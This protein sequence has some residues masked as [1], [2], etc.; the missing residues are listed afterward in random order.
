MKVTEL[1][2]KVKWVQGKRSKLSK[3]YYKTVTDLGLKIQR[4]QVLACYFPKKTLKLMKIYLKKEFEKQ[5]KNA[6]NLTS[7]NLKITMNEVKKTPRWNENLGKEAW[8]NA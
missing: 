7:G 5:E 8:Q 6:A 1:L 2:K 4:W 3:L